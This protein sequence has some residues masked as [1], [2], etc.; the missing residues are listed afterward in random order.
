MSAAAKRYRAFISYS[1]KDKPFARRLHRALEAYRVPKGVASDQVDAKSR[2]L[3]RFFR[4]DDEMAAATDLGDALQGAIADAESLIV[5]CSPHAARS[6]WVNEEVLHFKRTGRADKIFAVIVG[7]EPNAVR[8]E[9]ECF[10]AAL[11]FEIGADG[12]L[13]DH[14]AE[15]LGLD[16]RKETF[17]R[18]IVRLAAGLIDSP[19]DDLWRREQRRARG[20]A[21][22]LALIFVLIGA[23][24]AGSVTQNIWRPRL[25][26]F[27]RY[28]RFAQA[29]RFLAST[30]PGL[31]F[32]E[33]EPGSRLCPQMVVIPEGNFMMGAAPNELTAMFGPEYANIVDLENPFPLREIEVRRF[34]VS[35]HEV[36]IANWQACV[37]GGGCNG[38]TPEEENQSGEDLPVGNVSWADAQSYVRWLS[39]VTGRTYRLP[40]EAEWEYVARAQTQNDAPHTNYS[41]GD[42]APACRTDASN[43]AAFGPPQLI[44]INFDAPP[45]E[46][47]GCPEPDLWPVGSFPANA[48]G[49][50]DVHGNVAEWV[51]DCHAPYDPAKR[52]VAAVETRNCGFRGHRGGDVSLDAWNLMSASRQQAL[53]SIRSRSL[54]FRVVRDIQ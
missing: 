16:V 52:D 24:V 40:T 4:D 42:E 39:G 28:E 19:F 11:R 5:V 36:T 15:P 32:Q 23:I 53:P 45:V 21:V 22:S 12:A 49:V 9:R 41:W 20:R 3:G 30:Q 7:G 38:Y 48:F 50:H 51:Q 6:R 27:L 46:H 34:A 47:E 10:P 43:G 1:Q 2:K 54:G 29:H 33:C 26:A 25:E 35:R 13:T 44:A 8:V 37:D 14:P 18:I 31:Q 17:S